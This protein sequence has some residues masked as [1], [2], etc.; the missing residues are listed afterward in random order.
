MNNNSANNSESVKARLRAFI[1]RVFLANGFTK[2]RQPDGAMALDPYVFNAAE[3]LLELH[4]YEDQPA[5]LYQWRNPISGNWED[6]EEAFYKLSTEL[7]PDS[8]CFRKL[9]ARPIAREQALYG[10]KLLSRYQLGDVVSV[11]GKNCVVQGVTFSI[12]DFGPGLGFGPKIEYTVADQHGV[13]RTIYS[14]EASDESK[15]PTLSI[16]RSTCPKCNDSG[17]CDC[18]RRG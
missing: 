7:D 16:V 1:E 9:Y 4:Q 11:H 12:R 2:N 6:C 17:L 5:A 10:D 15:R 14:E 13:L 8:N 18:R 3:A